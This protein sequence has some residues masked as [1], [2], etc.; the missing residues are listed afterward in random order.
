VSDAEQ[1]VKGRGQGAPPGPGE[2]E[3]E[4]ERANPPPE[5]AE[6]AAADVISLDDEASAAKEAEADAAPVPRLAGVAIARTGQRPR[7]VIAIS[8]GKGGAGKT[9]L[10]V[11]LGIYLSTLGRT[12][13]VVDADR[14]GASLHSLLGV[15]PLLPTQATWRAELPPL[16]I[17]ATSVQGLYFMNGQVAEGNAGQVRARARRELFDALAHVDCD[18]LVLDLGA[19]IDPELL[20]AYLDADVA[21]YVTVPEPAAV[22]GTYRFVRALHLRRLVRRTSSDAQRSEMLALADELGGLPVPRELAE[23]LHADE[24]VLAAEMQRTLIEKPMHFVVNQTR[25]RA[26]LEL[27][28]SMR[29]AAWQRLGVSLDYIGYVDYDDTVWACVRERQPLLVKSPGTK[30]SKNIEKLARRL[31]SLDSGKIA[32]RTLRPVPSGTHH[33]LLEV[34]RGATDEEIRR[35]YRR[36]RDVYAMDALCCYGLFSE[37]ELSAVRARIE[38]AFDVLL[39]RARRRPYEL[40]V[41]PD[42]SLPDAEES[43]GDTQGRELPPSPPITPDTEFDG[44]LL[45]AVR[46]SRG[47]DL[48]Q[49]SKRTKIS[50]VYLAALEDD[51]FSALPALVYVRGFVAEVA[52]CLALD[53]IQVSHSYVRRVRRNLG[54]GRP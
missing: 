50:T 15:A 20:D 1:D 32:L 6:I 18:Y 37:R 4:V 2:I 12:T 35:A 33:D 16:S 30:A 31:I 44:A 17:E 51:D 7:R 25:V 47:Y 23:A 27:G 5:I 13:L 48:K 21:L 19:G 39:D 54:E 38:E 43:P 53:P 42:D 22:E 24:H 10:A 29:S 9:V 3:V 49:I 41:F 36:A 46:E 34:D 52:K 28:E 40:S 14:S 11:N 45:R 26:D 8:G